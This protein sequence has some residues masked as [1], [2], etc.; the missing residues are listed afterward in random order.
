MWLLVVVERYCSVN[1]FG[2]LLEAFYVPMNEVI[3][4]DYPVYSFSQ[5]ILPRIGAHAVSEFQLFGIPE[6]V[7]GIVLST[8]VGMEYQTGKVAAFSGLYRLPQGRSDGVFSEEPLGRA[9]PYYT[10]GEPVCDK[11]DV[12]ELASNFKI[13]YIALPQLVDVRY[14]PTCRQVWE[15]DHPAT[16]RC[17]ASAHLSY[18]HQTVHTA[19]V[20]ESVAAD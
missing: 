20:L 11:G 18:R 15:P 16:V 3:V 19:E 6:E 7:L 1:C 10:T 2:E 9:V 13:S 17:M 12:G 4:L 14:G 8:A 5:T